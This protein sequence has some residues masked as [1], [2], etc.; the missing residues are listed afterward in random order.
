MEN[1]FVIQ[2]LP[3]IEMY[4]GDTTPWVVTPVK[5]DGT[6]FLF[7]TLSE[8]NAIL[9]ITPFK[10]SMGMNSNASALTP[11]L[12]KNGVVNS[13]TFIFSFTMNDTKDLRGKFIYQIELHHEDDSRYCQGVL[14]IKQNTN[15]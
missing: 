10:A 2:T 15:R 1:S 7:D 3:D 8:C 11:I 5:E 4:G 6:T 13:Q 12:S 9:T 14:Y